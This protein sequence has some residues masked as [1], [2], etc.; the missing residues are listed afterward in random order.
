MPAARLTGALA[1]AACLSLGA[2]P[3]ALELVGAG[4]EPV[5]LALGPGEQGLVVHFWATWC[6]DCK[7]ELPA[8]GRAARGC[9]G[10]GVRVVAVNVGE[11][12]ETIAAFEAE[13]PIALPALRDPD[14]RAW[15]RFAR[16]LPANLVW[17]PGGQRGEVGPLDEAAWRAKLAGLGCSAAPR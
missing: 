5:R 6:A 2:A 3:A 9:E 8:L 13:Q 15:R 1:L 7:T 16:G 10:A 17:T 14:G 11:S 12:P 4:G